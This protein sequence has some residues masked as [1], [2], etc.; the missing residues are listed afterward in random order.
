M[1]RAILGVDTSC[2]MT[3]MALVDAS[4][5]EILA[6]ERKLLHV[7][8]GKR[9]L[10]QSQAVFAHVKNLPE[11]AE[12]LFHAAQGYELAAVCASTRPRT[13]ADDSYM[14][15]FCVGETLA[16]GMAAS[17]RVPF[18]VTSHQ[19]GHIRA[20][21]V[22]SIF[23]PQDEFLAMHLSG[24][25][26]QVLAYRGG[27]V[28]EI[29]G[30]G[31]LHAGQLVDR[32]G[33]ALHLPFPAGPELEKLALRGKSTAQLGVS[34][35]EGV[36]HFSGAETK[37][38]RWIQAGQMPPEDIAAEVYDLLCRTFLRLLQNGYE[39]TGFSKALLA[40]GVAS[41]AL[42]K[43]LLVERIQKRRI[44]QSIFFAKPE[45]SGDNAVGVALIGRA[46]WMQ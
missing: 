21:M 10:Q 14:P 45:L 1:K 38:L 17:H 41:S 6:S 4:D 20:A 24:G 16:R 18:Y 35:K 39:K 40:G 36:C 7:A 27:C 33:V 23:T 3:S 44:K 37:A 43:R 31:D 22:G 5:G 30:S 28:E 13:T 32:I 34:E 9:G 2:Y 25:T 15:V 29:G 11:V 12:R 42:L 26:T 46:Q 8:Q 19:D